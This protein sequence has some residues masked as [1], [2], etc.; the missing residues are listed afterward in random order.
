VT[1]LVL[2]KAG[3]GDARA[4]ARVHIASSEDAYAPLAGRWQA[5]DVEQRTARWAASLGEADR[6]VLVA[7][8][9]D[10]VVIGFVTGGPARRREPGA[11]LEI[12]AIHVSP[13]H[14]GRMVGD[15]LWNEACRKL[16]GPE[17]AAL[18]VDTLA[19]LRACSFYERRGGE[20][21]ERRATDFL[22]AGRTHVTYRWARGA[23]SDSR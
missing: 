16:R 12:Y 8:D 11:E 23:R 19:E 5:E 13:A 17:L 2:R 1:E 18:Y 21:V 9:A 14:R 6:L 15:A 7:E 20:V 22:G 10:G 4:I 3:V